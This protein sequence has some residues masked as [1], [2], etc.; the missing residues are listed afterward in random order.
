MPIEKYVKEKMP[1]LGFGAMR[2]PTLDGKIDMARFIE[3]V[4]HY[5]KSGANYFDTAWMYHENESEI[6]CREALVKRYPR[7]DFILATK[8]PVWEVK[9]QE[10]V[11]KIFQK[12]LE[13]CGVEFFDFYLIHALNTERSALCEQWKLF[14]Y[15]IE[16]QKQGKITYLGFSFHGKNECMDEICEKYADIFE[17]CQLQINYY[18]WGGDY[19]YQYERA[20]QIGLPVITMEPVRGGALAKLPADIEAR[21]KAAKPDASIASWAIRWCNELEGVCNV[22]SGMSNMEQLEDNIA[23]LRDAPPLTDA[24]KSL[25]AEAGLALRNIPSVPCTSCDYC[26]NCPEDIPIAAIFGMYNEYLK[27]LSTF[28]LRRKHREMEGKNVLDCTRCGICNPMCPQQ[29]DI[30]DYM[31][32]IAALIE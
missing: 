7:E 11:D 20:R 14:D 21:F 27:N 22:L 3:M 8:F 10:D 24:E 26:K 5:M 19:R 32:K 12:Q 17:F 4:D 31:G 18:D 25:I 15:L 9:E 6:A 30:P 13:K 16:Q 23:I 2:L 1:R 28:G 29:I